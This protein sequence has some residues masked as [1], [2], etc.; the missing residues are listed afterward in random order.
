MKEAK[1][2]CSTL[3]NG[4]D[5]YLWKLLIKKKNKEEFYFQFCDK[6]KSE[7]FEKRNPVFSGSHDKQCTCRLITNRHTNNKSKNH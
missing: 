7:I 4:F 2:K 5:F 1:T 6:T 3:S